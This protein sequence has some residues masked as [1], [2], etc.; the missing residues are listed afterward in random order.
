MP[1]TESIVWH[2][3]AALSQLGYSQYRAVFD[4]LSHGYDVSL[5]DND[6]VVY[7]YADGTPFLEIPL[8]E[9]AAPPHYR[10][11]ANV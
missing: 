5:D 1:S 3:A 9:V 2:L 8:A 6:N 10:H 4:R 11:L 7:S